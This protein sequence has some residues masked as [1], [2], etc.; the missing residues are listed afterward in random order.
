MKLLAWTVGSYAAVNVPFAIAAPGPWST[1]FRFN[2]TRGVDWDS[3]WFVACSRLHHGAASCGWSTALINRLSLA[4]FVGSAIAV[5]LLRRRLRPDFS[6]WTLAFPILVLFLLTNKVYSPQYGLWLLPWFAL[7]L[8]NQWL[9]VAFEVSDVAVFVTRFTWFGRMAG[10][11]GSPEFA[12]FHGAT[13]GAFQIALVVRAA[14]LVAC[15][16]AWILR[17]EPV[18]ERARAEVPRELG[19]VQAA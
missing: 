19:D 2:A 18:P 7:A 8:P 6:R 12:G 14:I 17:R 13:L 4:L 5:W 15:L 16:V 3:L 9:F 11:S 10:D 1:F